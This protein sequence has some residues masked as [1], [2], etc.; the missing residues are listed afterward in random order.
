VGQPCLGFDVEIGLASTIFNSGLFQ[1]SAFGFIIL[2][3]YELLSFL[4]FLV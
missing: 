4:A 3:E 1:V 2:I